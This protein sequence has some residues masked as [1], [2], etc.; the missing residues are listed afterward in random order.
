MRALL[1]YPTHASASKPGDAREFKREAERHAEYLSVMHGFE[2]VLRPFDNSQANKLRR[3][4]E[5][6]SL[7]R[8]Q[9]ID[10]FALFG[11]GLE[12]S[13][14]TGHDLASAATLAD[15]L[16]MGRKRIVVTLYACE[17]ADTNT[18]GP[19]GDGGFADVLRDLLA[20]RGVTG[21]V[22]AHTTTG[23]TTKNP[24][25]RRFWSNGVA[26]GTG[27]D[28]LVAPGSPKWRKWVAALKSTGDMRNAFPFLTPAE[29]DAK[30]E[31]L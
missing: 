18:K 14:Q 22:D 8:A 7:I 17:A 3:R 5:V 15:A 26:A 2:V 6:E 12:R 28:W 24:H 1:I 25:V 23:H 10:V 27:G 13:I 9:P 31:Q 20:E 16:S 21:H 29:I 19:G 30:L 11:H 4:R